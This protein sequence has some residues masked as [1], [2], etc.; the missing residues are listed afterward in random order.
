MLPK[1]ARGFV[2]GAARVSQAAQRHRNRQRRPLP[3]GLD[4]AKRPVMRASLQ[5]EQRRVRIFGAFLLYCNFPKGF[6][7]N[8]GW[9]S[10]RV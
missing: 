9:Y 8:E 3:R 2:F 5:R 7:T 4:G 10:P 1:G 6:P